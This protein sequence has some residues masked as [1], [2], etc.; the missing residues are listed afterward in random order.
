[1]SWFGNSASPPDANRENK[2]LHKLVAVQKDEIANLQRQL[3]VKDREHAKALLEWEREREEFQ[4]SI[5]IKDLELR[6]QAGVIERERARVQ[7]ET[8]A[9]MAAIAHANQ[10]QQLR[11]G[12]QRGSVLQSNPN[13]SGS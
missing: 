12:G 6:L 8:A 2:R 7:A 4:S 1:M 11:Q 10:L 5:T 9:Q 3:A 13:P